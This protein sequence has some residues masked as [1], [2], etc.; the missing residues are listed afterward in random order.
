VKVK[1]D[2]SQSVDPNTN[3]S[4][5][6]C[7]V[8]YGEA[9]SS[10]SPFVAVYG[11]DDMNNL[12]HEIK[13]DSETVKHNAKEIADNACEYIDSVVFYFPGKLRWVR[14]W[15]LPQ[16]K[17]VPT[18]SGNVAPEQTAWYGAI[19]RASE[20]P[21]GTDVLISW[22]F[23]PGT[24]PQKYG[25][26]SNLQPLFHIGN[27]DRDNWLGLSSLVDLDTRTTGRLN[28]DSVTNTL[29]YM[30]GSPSSHKGSSCSSEG[31]SCS[32]S[33][34]P[35]ILDLRTGLEYASGANV[36]NWIASV[37]V[38][39]TFA[40]RFWQMEKYSS[41]FSPTVGFE[42]GHNL[43]YS[44]SPAGA[45]YGIARWV[46]G[47]D[48]GTR[49]YPYRLAGLLGSKPYT[50]TGSFRV[51]FPLVA[52]DFTTN[53]G[54]S[55]NLTLSQNLTTR[56]RVYGKVELSQP[57]SRIVSASVLYQYGDLPPAFRFFGH[58]FAV[59]VRVSSPGD[60]EH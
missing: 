5:N 3:K 43:V 41:S 22:N 37:A 9:L 34:R 53:V 14:L 58:T 15:A 38:R 30:K 20:G 25:A 19:Q 18:V 52:E 31:P 36:L 45:N 54:Q 7:Y 4:N 28:P 10:E 26:Y 55:P 11:P 44:G 21:G 27:E 29:V 46:V 35:P 49:T 56:P 16:Q 47:A 1:L 60:Y 8:W 51:R 32:F 39:T 23:A 17:H 50:V 24:G 2:Q 13:R 6:G 59:S 33:F 42:A 12:K 48:A 57:L 40:A